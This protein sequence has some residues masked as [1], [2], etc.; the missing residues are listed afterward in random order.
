M[1]DANT[2]EVATNYA[3]TA[4]ELVGLDLNLARSMY[5]DLAADFRAGSGSTVR[6]KVPGATVASTKG[7]YDVTT[8]LETGS[9]AESGID[10]KLTTHAYSDVVLSEGELDLD[11]ESFS[12]QV[13]APQARAIATYVER[14]AAAAMQAVPASTDV[15]YDPSNPAKAFTAARRV[16]RT[17]GVGTDVPLIAAVGAGV[18]ADLLDAQTVNAPVFD[19][20]GK[21]RGF[22]V[23]EST[24]LDADELVFYVPEAFALVVRAPA[25]PA[26]A[27]FGA[28]VQT[29]NGFALRYIRSF[30]G[31]VAA[32]RSLVSAFVGVQELPLA[33]DAEDGTVSLVEHGGVVH[34]AAA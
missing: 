20:S 28:S 15:T 24:R 5:R 13:L 8:A 34:I 12:S 19:A 22:Q 23:I 26:G 31:S 30:D 9:I 7:I 6:I 11:I 27:P 32:D 1:A 17:N 2:F 14:T 16:L 33:V 21:V 4:A 29:D 25:V 10:V 3:A 18:Y